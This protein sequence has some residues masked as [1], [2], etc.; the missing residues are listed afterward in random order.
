MTKSTQSTL[1]KIKSSALREFE[2][3]TLDMFDGSSESEGHCMGGCCSL[4]CK[5]LEYHGGIGEP[6]G[7]RFEVTSRECDCGY[8]EKT[9]RLFS[10]LSHHLS[11]AYQAGVEEGREKTFSDVLHWVE[12]CG[13]EW[14]TNYPFEFFDQLHHYLELSANKPLVPSDEEGRKE[15]R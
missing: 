10:L 12:A 8:K 5:K 14:G 9:E 1:D 13:R 11:Q 2:C 3:L 7:G 6:C 15:K 4:C